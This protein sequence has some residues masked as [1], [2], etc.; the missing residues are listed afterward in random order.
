M[1][2]CP[3]SFCARVGRGCVG[4]WELGPALCH[5]EATAACFPIGP[6][7]AISVG[8]RAPP[9][10]S[11]VAFEHPHRGRFQIWEFAAHRKTRGRCFLTTHG[12]CRHPNRSC[13]CVYRRTKPH[14]PYGA[15]PWPARAARLRAVTRLYGP[16]RTHPGLP[17]RRGVRGGSVGVGD[18]RGAPVG[19]PGRSEGAI[20]L[21]VLTCCRC[22]SGPGMRA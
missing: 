11:H 13:L 10:E 5:Q 22:R 3:R 4:S 20:S 14:L 17:G 15:P 2:M 18:A 7:R 1:G 8:G 6:L 21:F 9:F 12:H 16:R 19:G